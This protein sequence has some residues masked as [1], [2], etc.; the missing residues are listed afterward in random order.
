MIRGAAARVWAIY[1]LLPILDLLCANPLDADRRQE[2][3]SHIPG[4]VRYVGD[5]RIRKALHCSECERAA[6]GFD[7]R[8]NPVSRLLFSHCVLLILYRDTLLHR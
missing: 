6:S 5:V 4:A 7:G 8:A 1:L 3:I 2:T